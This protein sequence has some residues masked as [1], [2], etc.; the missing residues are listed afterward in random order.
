MSGT[1]RGVTLGTPIALFVPNTNVRPGDYKEMSKVP[2]PGH[3]DY[4]YQAKYGNRASSGGGRSSARETIGRVGSGAV[5]EKWLYEAYGTRVVSWVTRIG[6]VDVP[7]E[8]L[9]NNEAGGRPWTR[10]E[11]D[12]CGQLRVLRDPKHW[13]RCS[14]SAEAAVAA[15][16]KEID[17]A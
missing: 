3:A 13:R 15:E 1:E 4:T 17:L 7:E 2:R 14:G 10:E 16:Q 12:R 11:V 9:Y 8:H 6:T 5:A